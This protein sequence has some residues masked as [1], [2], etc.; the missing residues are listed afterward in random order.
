MRG[1]C[2]LRHGMSCGGGEW[3]EVGQ[4]AGLWEATGR[5]AANYA[6][7]RLQADVGLRQ[8]TSGFDPK[9]PLNNGSRCRRDYPRLESRQLVGCIFIK[10][11]LL[12]L[13][14]FDEPT[15]FL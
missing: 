13:Q 15:D 10:H 6:G 7:F 3:R 5:L 2:R 4:A 9:R 1:A 8:Q 12:S 14:Q 11:Q